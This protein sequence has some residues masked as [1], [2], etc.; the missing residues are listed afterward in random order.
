MKA[1]IELVSRVIFYSLM[2]PCRRSVIKYFLPKR[3]IK[4]VG[5]VQITAQASKSPQ[6]VISLKLPLKTASPTGSVLIESEFV[7]IKGHIKL[8]QLE[9]NVKMDNVAIIG[10][11]RG[12]E[13]L[14]KV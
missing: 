9:M 8:F 1:L 6:T 11:A 4:I 13:I 14:Q 3:N 7:T 5:I 10:K 12:I 2:L